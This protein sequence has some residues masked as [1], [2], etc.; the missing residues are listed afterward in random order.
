MIRLIVADAR[1]HMQA[2]A[3]TFIVALVTGTAVLSQLSL[4]R[5]GIA[6]AKEHHSRQAVESAQAMAATEISFLFIAAIAILLS[7]TALAMAQRK[8]DIGLWRA[9]GMTSSRVSAIM[10]GELTI[11]GFIAGLL[12]FVLAMPVS[13]GFLPMLVSEHMLLKGTRP[14]L[15]LMDIFLS[16][17]IVA[18]T[19]ILGGWRSVRSAS[20][21]SEA[22]LLHG[23]HESLR[24]HSGFGTMI[25]ILLSV[26]LVIGFI[27]ALSSRPKDWDS[28][29]N[30]I[31]GAGFAAFAFIIVVSIWLS[32]AVE[33]LCGSLR[34]PSIPWYIATRTCAV[35]S[36]GS[37][38][39]VLPFTIAIGL[40]GLFFGWGTLGASGVT[41]AGMFSM[42]GPALIIAWVGGVGAIAISASRRQHDAAL[43]IAAGATERQL[44]GTDLLE[45]I[46]H[47]LAATVAGLT[48]TLGALLSAAGLFRISIIHAFMHGPWT[49]VGIVIAASLI[50][51]CVAVLASRRLTPADST[52]AML[53]GRD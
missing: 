32:P 42:F 3:W 21:V 8:R 19:S 44:L 4:M 10:L 40:T 52:I 22:L 51:T 27:A 1:D 25:R 48:I 31:T 5:G 33:R 14:V 9:L 23:E 46:V 16:A 20:R 7:T 18:A 2:W 17:L 30:A 41:P 34:F 35:E 50:T 13:Y 37:S 43:L 15:S 53:R 26:G 38:S 11:V 49:A 39:I 24:K 45:G 29:I 36:R 47:T 12:S 6:F 28:T